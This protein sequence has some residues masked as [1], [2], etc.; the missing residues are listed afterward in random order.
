Q[1]PH[2][3]LLAAAIATNFPLRQLK[4]LIQLYRAPR[5]LDLDGRASEFIHTLQAVI[6]GCHFATLM[7]QLVLLPAAKRSA[8]REQHIFAVSSQAVSGLSSASMT[9]ISRNSLFV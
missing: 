6:P 7:L 8:P 3:R 2:A 1:V 4:L 5:I 9:P